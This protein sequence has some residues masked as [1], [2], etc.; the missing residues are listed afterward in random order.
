[1][2]WLNIKRI[3][4]T[5]FVNFWRNGFVSL[6]TILVMTVTLFVIGSVIFLSVILRTSLDELRNKVDVNV[7]FVTS[8]QESDILV[9][10]KSIESLPEV[11][12][13][14]YVS[15][16]QVL[17][18]FKKRHENDSLTLQALDELGENPLGAAL[19]I[20]AVETSQYEGI[21]KFLEGRNVVS[22]DGAPIIDKVNF[23]QNKVAIDKLTKIIDSSERLGFAITTV[24]IVLSILITFNTIRLIIYISREEVSVMKLVGASNKYIRGPFMMSGLMYGVLSGVLVLLIF[25]PLTYWLGK[26]TANFFSGLNVFDYYL[27]NFGQISLIIVGTGIVLGALSSALAISKYLKV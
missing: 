9:L 19:N 1:M 20:R 14:E 16:E 2:I 6:S 13:V 10:K 7:Y 3:V 25:Y 27:S 18:N 5:G 26:A 15:R 22:T 11:A 4:K 23:Y 8:A 17:D 24:L 12:Q 21:A